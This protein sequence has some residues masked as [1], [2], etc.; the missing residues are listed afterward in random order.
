MLVPQDQMLL[1]SAKFK[2]LLCLLSVIKQHRQ[3]D[4]CEGNCHVCPF[5]FIYCSVSATG[6]CEAGRHG[7]EAGAPASCPQ[8]Q[9]TFQTRCAGDEV[10]MGDDKALHP[11]GYSEAEKAAKFILQVIC[12]KL[13]VVLMVSL[14]SMMHSRHCG[15]MS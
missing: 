3:G 5:V 6:V 11:P 4:W 10:P 12:L 1:T 2:F 15:E 9:C 7:K 8:P 13:C 14:P